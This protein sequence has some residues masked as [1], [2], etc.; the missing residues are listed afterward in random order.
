MNPI[1][2]NKL[3]LH[4]LLIFIFSIINYIL[5]KNKENIKDKNYKIDTFLDALYVTFITQMTSFFR[6]NNLKYLSPITKI[7][8]LCHMALFLLIK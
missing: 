4:F 5:S 2:T 6:Y 7:S 1:N 8:I 3:L